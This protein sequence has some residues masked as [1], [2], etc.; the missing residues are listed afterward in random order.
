MMEKMKRDLYTTPDVRILVKLQRMKWAG[1][2]AQDREIRNIQN[3]DQKSWRKMTT[4]ET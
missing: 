4:W 2:V 1:H 3:F